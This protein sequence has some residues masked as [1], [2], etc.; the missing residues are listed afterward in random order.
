MANTELQEQ[1]EILLEQ[2]NFEMDSTKFACLDRFTDI[3]ENIKLHR[4]ALA[5]KLDQHEACLIKNATG[6]EQIFMNALVRYKLSNSNGLSEHTAHDV[7]QE[8]RAKISGLKEVKAQIA[9]AAF[10]PDEA[11]LNF[12]T[13]YYENEASECDEQDSWVMQKI[14]Q[15]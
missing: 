9:T 8:M 4:A 14:K 15:K 6:A 3:R 2:F 5:E 7:F 10:Q 1:Y 13:L 12:G 11:P